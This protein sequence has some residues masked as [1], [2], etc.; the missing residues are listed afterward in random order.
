MDYAAMIRSSMKTRTLQT[1]ALTL[2]DALFSP[3]KHRP[4]ER[5][6]HGSVGRRHLSQLLQIRP[7]QVIEAAH[8][9]AVDVDDGDDALDPAAAPV[10]QNRH[11]NLA[12]AVA[13]AGNVAR[14]RAHVGHQ[15]R[16]RGGRCRAAD[17]SAKR[18]GLTRHFALERA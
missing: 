3:A 13:V 9:R 18:D 11:D 8:D 1:V 6:E 16:L 5:S 12:P 17:A 7:V 14:E 2:A 10:G 15:L 4:P